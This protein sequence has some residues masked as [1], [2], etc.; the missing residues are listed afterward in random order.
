MF[1]RPDLF[2][3]RRRVAGGA[4]RPAVRYESPGR[5]PG[6]WL[7]APIRSRWDGAW[8]VPRISWYVHS[9]LFPASEPIPRSGLRACAPRIWAPSSCVFFSKNQFHQPFGLGGGQGHARSNPG[10]SDSGDHAIQPL[11]SC[12]ETSD[13][14]KKTRPGVL[15]QTPV[16]PSS[17]GNKTRYEILQSEVPA[18][19]SNQLHSCRARLL[20]R[21]RL[22]SSDIESPCYSRRSCLRLASANGDRI[23]AFRDDRLA[24]FAD[25]AQ[26]SIL[27]IEVHNL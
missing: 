20:L 9:T 26:I 24:G 19:Q 18:L 22:C 8:M 12:S 10:G 5:T 15:L 6:R 7:P 21:Q 2:Q 17:S 16:F 23:D 13:P 3:H 14:V 27:E 1:G 11:Y 4:E 25:H